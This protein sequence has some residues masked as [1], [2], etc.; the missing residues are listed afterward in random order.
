[1]TYNPAHAT[2]KCD[3]CGTEV[4]VDMNE[5]AEEIDFARIVS[6]NDWGD[7][8]KVFECHN[9]GARQILGKREISPTCAFCGTHNVVETADL[10]GLKPNALLPF[11]ISKDSASKQYVKWAKK[12][13]FAPR[14]FK[15]DLK[16]PEKIAGH[17]YPAFTF[18][19]DTRTPYS[20]TLGKH[21]YTTHR[22]SKGNI[23]RVRHTRYFNISGNLSWFF[24]DVFVQ[25]SKP[26]DTKMLKKL[27][28]YATDSAHKYKEDFLHGFSASQYHKS[29]MECWQEARGIM[30]NEVRSRILAKY[31]YDVIS[32]FNFNMHCYSTTYKYLLI[33]VYVG[34]TTYKKKLYNF[35][36]NG[37]SGKVWGKTPKSPLKI[38]I[39][40]LLG[41]LAVAGLVVLGV[42]LL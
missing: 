11:L 3:Y 27:S 29:G 24:N 1:M 33:P 41:A 25:A 38:G 15:K 19:S 4:K 36:M 30:Q 5:Y 14:E 31:D 42:L 6:G 10:S 8:T 40:A 22:D 32:S 17:Y 35:Y 23:K 18:D 39:T 21:Y 2:L 37:Q 16:S 20:G 7:E 9:C 28:P 12:K 26:D 34:H 13:F